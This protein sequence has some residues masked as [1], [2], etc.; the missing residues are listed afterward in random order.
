MLLFLF[1]IIEKIKLVFCHNP[2]KST[3]TLF[4]P[5]LLKFLGNNT[6]KEYLD[7]YFCP[8]DMTVLQVA[9][10]SKFACKF[11]RTGKFNGNPFKTGTCLFHVTYIGKYW[12]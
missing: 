11:E 9:G 8:S 5:K 10:Y 4:E 6:S 3:G 2:V 7:T 1:Y 12:L